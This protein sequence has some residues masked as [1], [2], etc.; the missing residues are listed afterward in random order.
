MR[1]TPRPR[2]GT[3]WWH[4][5]AHRRAL[6]FRQRLADAVDQCG[7][8]GIGQGNDCRGAGS[9]DLSHRHRDPHRPFSAHWPSPARR[10]RR[11]APRLD[12]VSLQTFT[13]DLL[14]GRDI[15]IVVEDRGPDVPSVQ[16]V[17]APARF[18]PSCWSRHS[19]RPRLIEDP[20]KRPDTIL[21]V[22]QYC[23]AERFIST[24]KR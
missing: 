19:L 10:R 22:T 13:Q 2:R 23:S 1:P 7:N 21:F 3:S 6:L 14:E 11:S 16:S 18:V 20:E 8:R 15:A 9:G 12:L 17:V 5:A 24:T 4:T